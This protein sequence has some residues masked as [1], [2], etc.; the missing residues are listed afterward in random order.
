MTIKTIIQTGKNPPPSYVLDMLKHL[1][2]GWEYIFFNDHDIVEFFKSNPHYEFPDIARVFWSFDN[3][4]H[5]ADLFRYYY[6]YL[7]GGFYL[8]TDAMIYVNLDI[9]VQDF[10][11]VSVKSIKPCS[12]FQG[13]LYAA[14]K[15]KIIY[16]A[17]KDAYNID[18]LRLRK[19]YHALTYNLHFIIKKLEKERD[20]NFRYQLYEERK[21]SLDFICT[22]DASNNVIAKHYFKYKIIPL[23]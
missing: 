21:G 18:P 16:E 20:I 5:R 9:I 3:G 14:P 13:L 8:D 6:L 10:Q 2:S 17:L 4:A 19:N 23:E 1:S 7:Y 22:V 12:I 15:N 11:F